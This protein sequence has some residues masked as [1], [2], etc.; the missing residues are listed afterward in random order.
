[1]EGYIG[2]L[3]SVICVVVF[4][5]PG[6]EAAG[7]GKSR[8]REPCCFHKYRLP[9]LRPFPTFYHPFPV[10]SLSPIHAPLDPSYLGS[11]DPPLGRSALP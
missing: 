9:L 5:P 3:F 10:S 7:S 2:F 1:M 8:V 4:D 11:L 6:L